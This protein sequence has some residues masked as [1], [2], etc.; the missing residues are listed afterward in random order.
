MDM[1]KRWRHGLPYA[2]LPLILTGCGLT[3]EQQ[4][5][6]TVVGATVV[7][8]GAP[9]QEVE[10][11]YYLGIFDPQEQIPPSVYRIRVHGQASFLS[12]MQFASGWVPA[13]M[14]DSLGVGISTGPKGKVTIDSANDQFKP[15]KAGRR[16]MMFG[17][18][19]FREAPAD[20]RLVIV[21]GSSPEVFFNAIN[22]SLGVVAMA[23]QEQGSSTLNRLLFETLANLRSRQQAASDLLADTKNDL[24]D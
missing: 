5:S 9:A 24:P 8:A 10:Q 2:L 7:G 15:F 20:H 21:M 16:L 14:A 23:T 6:A 13:H 1:F 11:V 22:D 18:E 12:G 17:P 3:S 4:I 19:G